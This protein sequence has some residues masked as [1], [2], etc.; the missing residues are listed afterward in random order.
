MTSL[1]EAA[2]YVSGL[3]NT[4][5]LLVSLWTSFSPGKEKDATAAK[6]AELDAEIRRAEGSIAIGQGAY[7]EEGGIAMGTDAYAGRN[8]ISIGTGAGGGAWRRKLR[9]L[10]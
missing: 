6:I 5:D 3:K 2:A 7:A 4:R 9:A 10:E 1:L 8:S